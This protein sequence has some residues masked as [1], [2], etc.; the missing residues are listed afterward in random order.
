MSLMKLV[1]S[2][3]PLRLTFLIWKV[4]MIIVIIPAGCFDD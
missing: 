4:G 3:T 1:E 2:L